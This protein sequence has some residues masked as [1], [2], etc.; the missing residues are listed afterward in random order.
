MKKI[1]FRETALFGIMYE[2]IP[3]D[4]YS[5]ERIFKCSKESC[6]VE[7]LSEKVWT[8]FLGISTWYILKE[9]NHSVVSKC[10]R[11][12]KRNKTTI[13]PDKI[14]P[15]K[16]PRQNHPSRITP[17][18]WSPLPKITPTQNH[19]CHNHPWP[20]SPLTKIT[21][22]HNHPWHNHPWL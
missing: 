14:T 6:T 7:T 19:P 4:G 5:I 2:I 8:R 20:Q 9:S 17:E 21:P 13:T 16:S 1:W 12:F 10:I 3:L 22:T 15:P 18:S 11:E